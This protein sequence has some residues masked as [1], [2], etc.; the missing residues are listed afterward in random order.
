MNRLD[1]N[2]IGLSEVLAGQYVSNSFKEAI[3][4]GL[5]LGFLVLRPRGLF[6]KTEF[7]AP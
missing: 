7:K 5:L 4:F 3:T 6:G 1:I 2:I